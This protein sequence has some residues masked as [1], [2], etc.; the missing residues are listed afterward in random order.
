MKKV[1]TSN[2]GLKKLPTEVRNKMGYM[3]KGGVA[4]GF[5]PCAGCP[6]AAK[7]KAAGKCLAKAKKK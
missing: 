2:K 6:S 4:K 3:A 5:K 1:P 7:C